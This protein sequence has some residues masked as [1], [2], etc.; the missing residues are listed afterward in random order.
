MYNREFTPEKIISLEPNEIFVFGS[1]LAGS[2]GGGAARIAYNSFG[3]IWGQGVGFQGQSYAIPTMQ[4]GVETIKP[5]VDE[6]LAFAKQHSKMKFYVTRIGCGIAGF[7]D[8][9]MAPLFSEAFDIENVIL[10][11]SFVGIIS[12]GMR[13][14]D[15]MSTMAFKI[16]KIKFYDED[17]AY[18]ESLSSHEEKME[19]MRRL[20]QE[21]RYIELDDE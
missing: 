13:Y 19:F 9:D 2:H 18:F 14:A 8:E 17:L 4:G 10:P 11:R 3:A 7:K 16:K 1:N 5:Y 6:F 12:T 15:E 20:R 21:K